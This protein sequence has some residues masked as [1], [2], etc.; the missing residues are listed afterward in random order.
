MAIAIK[1]GQVEAVKFLLTKTGE[2]EAETMSV[3][4]RELSIKEL[5]SSP[6]IQLSKAELQSEHVVIIAACIIDNPVTTSLDLSGNRL[7]G[8]DALNP[9]FTGVQTLAQAIRLAQNLTV[10][11]IS[12]NGLGPKGAGLLASA[13]KFS[14]SMTFL[15]LSSNKLTGERQVSNLLISAGDMTGIKAIADALS[16]SSS[17]NSL[18]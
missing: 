13:M 7:L 10:L 3:S 6:A 4:G 8:E 16:V 1:H 11:D 18:K 14:S 12:S 2:W 9:N 15:D 5:R 17:M